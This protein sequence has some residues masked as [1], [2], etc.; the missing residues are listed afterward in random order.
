MRRGGGRGARERE[1]RN[2][3][4]GGRGVSDGEREKENT[5]GGKGAGPGGIASPLAFGRF[6]FPLL[7]LPVA[8]VPPRIER[9]E[10]REQDG[11]ECGIRGARD[12]FLHTFRF[13]ATSSEYIDDKRKWGR[14]EWT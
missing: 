14:V 10:T 2:N 4:S 13:F 9:E 6:P 12:T 7:W 1:R 5:Q 8:P 11:S 3:R